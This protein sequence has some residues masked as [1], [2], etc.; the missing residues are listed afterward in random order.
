MT[1]LIM[2]NQDYVKLSY[3]S[4]IFLTISWETKHGLTPEKIGHDAQGVVEKWG[5]GRMEKNFLRETQR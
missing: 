4:L 5:R 1:A 3:H 2:L